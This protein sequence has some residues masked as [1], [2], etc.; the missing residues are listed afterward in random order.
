[1]FGYKN[2]SAFNAVFSYKG[3]NGIFCVKWCDKSHVNILFE[4]QFDTV[5][6]LIDKLMN[7][8]GPFDTHRPERNS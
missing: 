8:F 2:L 3:V 5:Y 7:E 4:S 1:M 6:I